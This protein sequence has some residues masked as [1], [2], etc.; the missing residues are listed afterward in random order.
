MSR[1]RPATMFDRPQFR[2]VPDV[3]GTRNYA[4]VSNELEIARGRRVSTAPIKVP[5]ALFTLMREVMGIDPS[6]SVTLSADYL[7]D[8]GLDMYVLSLYAK[9]PDQEELYDLWELKPSEV[10]GLVI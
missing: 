5:A 9:G 3:E 10:E 7:S 2:L 8:Y 4:N 1:E 6:S